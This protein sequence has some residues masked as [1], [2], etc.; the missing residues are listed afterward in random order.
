VKP[1]PAKEKTSTSNSL[2]LP[3]QRFVARQPIFDRS[4]NV[5]G[6]EILFRNGIEDYF[7]TDPELA[8]RSTVD[9]SLLFGI[10]ILVR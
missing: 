6:Y 7:N 2:A 1:A 10:N 3:G 5:F 8:A 9:S 4:Q